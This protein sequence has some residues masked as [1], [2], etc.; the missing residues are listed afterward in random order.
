MFKVLTLSLKLKVKGESYIG[1][2]MGMAMTSKLST[3]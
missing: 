2:R 1:A 3:L